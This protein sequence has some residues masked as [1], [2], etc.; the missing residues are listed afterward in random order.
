MQDVNHDGIGILRGLGNLTYQAPLEFPAGPF[1]YNPAFG[2]FN[3]DGHIDF[4]VAT[5]AGIAL[6]FG[7][8]DGTLQAADTYD[9]GHEVS[10]AASGDFNGDKIPDLA[11]GIYGLTPGFFLAK[12]T[13]PSRLLQIRA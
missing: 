12:V 13:A 2:D 5:T 1:P 4:A 9:V 10:S 6:F 11:V 8:A 7:N 3:G